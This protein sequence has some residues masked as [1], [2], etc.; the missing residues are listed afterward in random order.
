MSSF[1]DVSKKSLRYLFGKQTADTVGNIPRRFLKAFLAHGVEASQ[2]PRL[3]PQIKFEDVQSPEKLLAAL[4]PEILD[5]TAQLFGIRS[6]WLAGIEDQIYSGFYAYKRPRELLNHVAPLCLPDDQWLNFPLRVLATTLNLDR[7]NS[8]QQLLIPIVVER[9]AELGEDEIF[10][11][12]IY[13]DGFD[14]SYLPARVE[15]KAVARLLFKKAG[16]GVPLYPVSPKQMDDILK[17]R[18]FPR[19]HLDG[20]LLTTPSLEDF[21]L[22]KEESGIAKEVEELPAVLDYIEEHN[23]QSFSFPRADVLEPDGQ[24]AGHVGSSSPPPTLSKANTLRPMQMDKQLCQDTAKKLWAQYPTMTIAE[25]YRHNELRQAG[26]KNY[27]DKTLRSWLSPVAPP[28]VR[29]KRGRPKK[30]EAT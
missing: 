1:L 23:L 14:W 25:M 29:A 6:Q 19:Q 27:T 18:A 10:R 12:H 21:A 28:H 16:I 24:P 2:I 4:T 5:Q 9:I 8:A 26:G 22:S 20:C 15:L 11:Y 30:D 13:K 17:G 3:L 7:N